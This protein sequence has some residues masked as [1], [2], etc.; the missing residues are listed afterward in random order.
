MVVGKI[1]IGVNIHEEE[2]EIFSRKSESQL[3][4]I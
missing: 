4:K 2:S 1:F 3:M